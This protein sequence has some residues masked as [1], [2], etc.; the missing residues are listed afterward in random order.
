MLGNMKQSDFQIAV[1]TSMK[2]DKEVL[3][4]ISQGLHDFKFVLSK[5]QAIALSTAIFKAAQITPEEDT[6]DDTTNN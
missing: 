5:E 6:T 4:E 2:G 3:L 1:Y